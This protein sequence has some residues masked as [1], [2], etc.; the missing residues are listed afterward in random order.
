M[1]LSQLRAGRSG[2]R[3]LVEE[4][5]FSLLQGS[6]EPI[7]VDAR[8]KARLLRLRVRIPPVA[9]MSISCECCV[10]S[11]RGLCNGPIT[12]PAECDVSDCDFGTSIM[13]RPRST[14]AVESI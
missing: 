14:R 10:L 5:D 1:V 2:L 11:N 12:R 13:R 4:R 7:P 8:F 6:P 9:W 3:I